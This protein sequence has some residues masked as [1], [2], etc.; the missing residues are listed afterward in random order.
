[1]GGPWAVTAMGTSCFVLAI[2]VALL[3]PAL[4]KLKL[5]PG[6]EKEASQ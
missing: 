4:W 5:V 1:M 2:V 3:V 6:F